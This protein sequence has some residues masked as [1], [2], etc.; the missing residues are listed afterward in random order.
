MILCA[1][2]D[3]GRVKLD[4]LTDAGAEKFDVFPGHTCAFEKL[5]LSETRS[6]HCP[7]YIK[8]MAWELGLDIVAFSERLDPRNPPSSD[9]VMAWIDG[10]IQTLQSIRELA[11]EYAKAGIGSG[12][13]RVPEDFAAEQEQ[14][15][16]IIQGIR[17]AW[18]AH[19]TEG[20]LN[21]RIRE[22]YEARHR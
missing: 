11:D 10:A 2:T 14:L 19:Y 9:S 17:I 1:V 21:Q 16:S 5:L 8:Q 7:Q 15:E 22:A 3:E 6:E 13:V 20:A 12:E 4:R 18:S